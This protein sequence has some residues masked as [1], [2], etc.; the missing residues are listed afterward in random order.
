MIIT[1]I[2]TL[3]NIRA[4]KSIALNIQ[5]A[6]ELTPY[7]VEAQNFDLSKFMGDSFF[8]DLVNDYNSSPSLANYSLLYNGGNYTHEGKSY[9]FSGIKDLLVYYSY[10]RYVNNSGVIATPTGFVAKTNNY[11]EQ[12]TDKTISRLVDTARTCA[13]LIEDSLNQYLNRKTS[14]YPLWEKF[15]RV[16]NRTKIRQV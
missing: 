8:L 16:S 3:D 7:I 4:I 2:I 13:N 12:V 14:E 15:K 10:A 11:S 6:K 5:Q 9:Y 1:P